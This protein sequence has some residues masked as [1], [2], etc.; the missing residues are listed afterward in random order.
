MRQQDAD[1]DARRPFAAV[2][3]TTGASSSTTD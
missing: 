3:A 1:V 2:A